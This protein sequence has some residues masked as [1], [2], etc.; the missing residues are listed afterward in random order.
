MAPNGRLTPEANSRRAS[1]APNSRATRG[2]TTGSTSSRTSVE[3]RD[4]PIS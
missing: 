3:E 2:S 1:A 4:W